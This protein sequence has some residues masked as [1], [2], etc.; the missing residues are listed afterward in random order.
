MKEWLSVHKRIKMESADY[1][2]VGFANQLLLLLKKSRFYNLLSED[3]W[4]KAVLSFA[5]YFEDCIAD[6]GN[7][8]QFMRWHY[9]HYGR[10]IPFYPLTDEYVTDEVNREDVAFL[11][12]T[13]L[14]PPKDEAPDLLDP[15]DS[16]LQG[17][18]DIIY[19]LINYSFEQAPVNSMISENWFVDSAWLEKEKTIVP[20]ASSADVLPPNV[21]RFLNASGGEPL[22]FFDSY[23]SLRRF[24]IDALRWE[25][26][27]ESLL[28][29]LKAWDN[30]VLYANA[31]GMLVAPGVARYFAV[32]RNTLYNAELASQEAY[33]LFTEPGLCPF[34]LL[35][36]G[37]E[38]GLLPDA[39]FPFANGKRLLEENWDFVARWFLRDYYEGD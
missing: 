33:R 6:T 12:W 15:F 9:R 7:W 8:R 25:E 32:A 11:L 35:K 13:L 4:Q 27:D 28:P 30:F 16:N 36:Y 22:L 23:A 5:L 17:C 2:Y 1:W 10:Y 31:K 24:F 34:D 29:E 26:H 21:E 19:T 38:Q 39:Q 14:C 20:A 18:T 3:A 37:M